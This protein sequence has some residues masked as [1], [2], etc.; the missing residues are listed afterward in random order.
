MNTL[1]AGDHL[2]YDFTKDDF[3]AV[4]DTIVTTRNS[5]IHP[6][7]LVDYVR[8]ACRMLKR[9]PSFCVSR[10]KNTDKLCKVFILQ[11]EAIIAPYF[12]IAIPDGVDSSAPLEDDGNNTRIF[13]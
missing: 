3:Y 6:E 4:A 5:V 2:S 7:D 8:K 11:F 13:V 12:G 9:N 1:K 10:D